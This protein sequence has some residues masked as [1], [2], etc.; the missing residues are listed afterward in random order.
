[1]VPR[2]WQGI[3]VVIF[4]GRLIE[5]ECVQGSYVSALQAAAEAWRLSVFGSESGTEL[6]P[7]SAPMQTRGRPGAQP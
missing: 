5:D 3:Q 6:T 2:I 1:M 7:E 4:L